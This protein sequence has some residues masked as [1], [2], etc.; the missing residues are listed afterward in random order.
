MNLADGYMH[1]AGVGGI[2]SDMGWEISKTKGFDPR[3]GATYQLDPKTVIRAGYGRSFDTGVFGS[4][5]GHVVTQNLPVLADQ[6][7][8][9]PG[10]SVAS[11]YL[12]SQSGLRDLSSQQCLPTACCL[13]RHTRSA[14]RL[15]PSRS[16]SRRSTPGT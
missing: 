14:P 15:A 10:G 12:T 2:P 1:V 16:T 3:I 5:F 11:E 13:H 9:E 8:N 7:L 4:I 6:S